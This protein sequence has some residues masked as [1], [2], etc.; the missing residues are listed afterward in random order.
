LWDADNA[1]P[2]FNIPPA[3]LVS[4]LRSAVAAAAAGHHHDDG[5]SQAPPIIALFAN[6]HT[7]LGGDPAAWAAAGVTIH[8]T[9]THPGAADQAIAAAAVD[10][11]RDSASANGGTTTL[12]ALASADAGFAGLVRWAGAQPGVTTVVI[13]AFAGARPGRP[14]AWRWRGLPAAAHGAAQWIDVVGRAAG[15]RDAGKT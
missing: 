15:V 1:R 9:L 11:L 6:G 13:G 8:T 7:A 2:P 10:F 3:V 12:L 5:W 14:D 4:E